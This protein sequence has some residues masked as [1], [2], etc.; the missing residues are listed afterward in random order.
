MNN[1][2][3]IA[4]GSGFVGTSL[5]YSLH[6]RGYQV[7][8][9]SRSQSQSPS[10]PWRVVSWNGRSVGDWANEL[11]GAAA[12]INIAGRTV[13]CIKTPD[14]C[15]EIL[16]SRVE[17]TRVLGGALRSIDQPPL[18]W[19]QMSTAHLYGDPPAEIC[20]E[21]SAF[22]YG[23]APTVA[24][25]WEEAFA[26]SRLPGQRVV[27]FRTSFVLGKDRGAGAGALNRLRWLTRM[28]LGG[29]IGSGRQG[30]SWIHEDDL[31]ALFLRSIEEETMSGAYIASSPRP[32]SQKAFTQ[33]LRQ[34][35]HVKIGLPAPEWLIRLGAKYLLKTDP[36]LAL[37]GRYVVSRRLR[38]A[39]F[40]FRFD[41]VE[42]ALRTILGNQ[43]PTH[44]RRELDK[45]YSRTR[46]D[47]ELLIE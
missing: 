10:H 26:E 34:A 8:V 45:T 32:V 28:G 29:T 6:E 25:A 38:E 41:D 37:C 4:G 42:S 22:G 44:E 17:S 16:R 12:L 3:V 24:R 11:C 21:D 31:N 46:S 20:D 36:E 19:V 1:Q 5:A 2:I 30:I 13:D 15:D 7:V 35:C 9:L 40:Q 14:H 33:A 39:G 27:I 43:S 18:I 23:L 47:L